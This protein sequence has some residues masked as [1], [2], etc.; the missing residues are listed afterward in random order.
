M[1]TNNYKPMIYSSLVL[2]F[3][4]ALTFGIIS[5]ANQTSSDQSSQSSQTVS[6]E[7]TSEEDVKDFCIGKTFRP[8]YLNIS[9]TV[10]SSSDVSV[11]EF[12]GSTAIIKVWFDMS[13]VYG[14][15][16]SSGLVFKIDK[17]TGEYS[18]LHDYE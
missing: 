7:F 8:D 14:R 10:R 2:W 18:Q 17:R 6:S 12:S 1:E 9:T 11:K 3:C 4:A 15:A 5:C 16:I 13:E